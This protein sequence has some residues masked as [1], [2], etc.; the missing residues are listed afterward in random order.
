MSA[1]E[2]RVVSQRE[3]QT[4]ALIAVLAAMIALSATAIDINLPVIPPMIEAL[5]ADAT[6]GQAVVTV[7]LAGFALGQLP[8]GLAADRW[9]R[10]PTALCAIAAFLACSVVVS[11]AGNIYVL[12]VARFAQGFFGAVGP[13]LSRTISRDLARDGDASDLLALLM[14]ILALA[15]I[16]APLVGAALYAMS[17]WRAP[18]WALAVY[19]AL[20]LVAAAAFL[21]ETRGGGLTAKNTGATLRDVSRSR[22]FVSAALMIGVPHAGY[23]GFVTCSSTVLALQYNIDAVA[24]AWLFALAAAGLIAG[25]FA[26]RLLSKSVGKDVLRH[27]GVTCIA[28]ASAALLLMALGGV[29]PLALVWGAIVLFIFGHGIG[30]PLFTARALEDMGA[31]AGAAAALMGTSQILLGFIGSLAAA[32]L[33]ALG[34]A[35]L[36][37]MVGVP[38]LAAGALYWLQQRA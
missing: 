18:Y 9:G 23:L 22:K 25:G 37:L 10:R 6:L 17:D 38:G 3:R 36:A 16:L 34:G 11:A 30:G 24:F 35:G 33:A 14:S 29:L 5:G 15:P 12:L 26:V 1:S 8:V 7:Y 32:H 20:L 28:T 19:G 2:A 13:V 31:S 27:L 21:P 4:P